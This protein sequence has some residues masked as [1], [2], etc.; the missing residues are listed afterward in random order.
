MR[1]Q[2]TDVHLGY[3][4][5]CGRPALVGELALPFWKHT[6]ALCEG[7]LTSLAGIVTAKGAELA[8]AES[9]ASPS[10]A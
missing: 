8:K 9:T 6:L 10:R 1:V 4:Y 5:E 3:C 7:C 2:I